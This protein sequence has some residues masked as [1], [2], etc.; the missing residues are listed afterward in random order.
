MGGCLAIAENVISVRMC[1]PSNTCSFL[2]SLH[3]SDTTRYNINMK[4]EAAGS[5][6]MLVA[7]SETV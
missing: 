6:K 1:L 3:S 7:A 5:F 2:R 4:K